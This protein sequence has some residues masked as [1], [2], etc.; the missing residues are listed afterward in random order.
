MDTVQNLIP[1]HDA[2]DENLNLG[3]VPRKTA[4][5]PGTSPSDRPV[6]LP[7]ASQDI[8]CPPVD[9]TDTG[10]A[11]RV[12]GADNASVRY[13]FN[14]SDTA[15]QCDPA[16]PGQV[17][18]KV[19]VRGDLVIGQAGSAGT[20]T[21]PLRVEVAK[22]GDTKPVFSKTYT[23]SANADGVRPGVF[24]FVTDP[25][26]LPMPT[27]QLSDVYTISVGFASGGH[28]TDQTPRHRRRHSS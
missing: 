18:I 15:R 21:A 16:G 3:A 23:I 25:I 22:G 7:V 24:Q 28:A 9:V 5:T 4:G 10:A 20:M 27:L 26:V 17:A 6:V 1:H 14:I 2:N 13:Q 8:N 19:G 11:L 12:G